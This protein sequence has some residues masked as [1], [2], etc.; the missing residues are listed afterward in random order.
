[1]YG[2]AIE[3]ALKLPVVESRLFFCTAAGGFT[4]RVI[5]LNEIAR[6]SGGTVLRTIQRAI[7]S[8]FLVPAPREDACSW[9][10]F[11][12]VCGPYEE[13]R[14]AQKD[15]HTQIVQLKAVRDLD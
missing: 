3:T 13:L 15:E 12:E 10:D 11:Q 6:E 8:G 14:I 2:L 5:P 4:E 9:C 7:A 1:L